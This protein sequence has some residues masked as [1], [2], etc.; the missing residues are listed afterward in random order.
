L[1]DT[2][3]QFHTIKCEAWCYEWAGTDFIKVIRKSKDN[4]FCYTTTGVATHCSLQI[5]I[6]QNV[7]KASIDLKSIVLGGDATYYCDK[8]Y[9]TIDKNMWQNGIMKAEFSF[10]FENKESAPKP[11]FW[12]GIILAKINAD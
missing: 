6:R 8:G 3:H 4:I 2:T 7:C 1:L 10:H 11:M 9:I 5:E 12:K